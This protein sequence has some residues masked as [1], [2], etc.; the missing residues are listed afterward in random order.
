MYFGWV[1][2]G[3]FFLFFFGWVF[4]LPTLLKSDPSFFH[5]AELTELHPTSFEIF[6]DNDPSYLTCP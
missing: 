2:L 6:Y 5:Q 3:V 4:R 1:F